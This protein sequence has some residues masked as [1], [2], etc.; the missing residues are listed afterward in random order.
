MPVDATHLHHGS[1]LRLRLGRRVRDLRRRRALPEGWTVV[2]NVGNGQVWK[3]TD[4]GEPRQPDRRRAAASP[5]IDSDDYG[6]G[7]CA[8]HLAGQPR[9]RPDRRHRPGDPV[10]P[11]LQPP[12]R[13]TA[14]VD[15]SLDGGATWTN[16]LQAGRPTS[17][18]RARTRSRSR[19]PPAS[20]RSRSASTTTTRRTSGGGRSTTCSSAAR[21]PARRSTAAWS[22]ATSATRTTTAAQRRD[23]HQR[24]QAGREGRHRGDPG[25]P[26]AG[27]RLLLAV[28][29]ADRRAPVR[30]HA[31]RQTTSA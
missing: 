24:R 8:G 25:R 26:G 5:I 1:R 10:Q 4:D 3:F 28:L 11:G 15:L 18:G 23:R 21:S 31:R 22:S 29:V 27:R 20:R 30:G 13:R 14:D 9:G 19:R 7:G 6:L 16:V 12:R 17:A 2:D